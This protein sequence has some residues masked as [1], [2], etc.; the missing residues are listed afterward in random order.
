MNDYVAMVVAVVL[1]AGNAFF[2]GA[3]FSLVSARRSAVEARA[4][5]GR[6]SARTTLR[7]MEEVSLMMACA[8]LGITLCSLGL[9]AIGE[10]AVAHQLEPVFA[11]VGLPDAAVYPVSFAIALLLVVFLHVVL[12]EMVPKNIALAGPDRVALVLTPALVVCAKVLHPVIWSMNQVANLVLRAVGVQPKDEVTSA[13][14]RDEV[15]GLVAESRREGLLAHGEEAL[16]LGA[17][18]FA[19]RTAAAVELPIATVATVPEDV[20]VADVEDVARRTG[21]SRFPVR[22]ADGSLTGYVHVKDV[23][24]A[25]DAARAA[26][27]P[28]RYLRPLATVRP[29]D[30]LRTVLRRMQ[31]TGAH[32]ARV[33]GEDGA[34]RGIVALE[35]VLEELVGEVRSGTTGFAAAPGSRDLVGRSRA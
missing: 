5:E 16:A 27:V 10:P 9:G 17:L 6:R 12:G 29:G 26:H 33:V 1:L 24:T 31:R 2:V 25:D 34:L 15:S 4:A 21:F 32:L 7:A 30:P 19:D 8:Q 28:S 11:A 13:F 14:T 3:E 35:D 18:T 23:L 20:R 22:A